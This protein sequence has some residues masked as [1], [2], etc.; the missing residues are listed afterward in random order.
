MS[1]KIKVE[2]RKVKDLFTYEFNNKNHTEKQINFLV[3]SITEFWFNT[4]II[5][6]KNN[7]IIAG[8]WRL[9]AAKKLWLEEV[10]VVE[11]N[12]LTPAQVKKYRLLDN[13]IA[14]LAEDNEENIKMELLELQDPQLNELYDFALN[15]DADG[16]WDDFDLPDED[17][18]DLCQM[19]FTLHRDQKEEIEKAMESAALLGDYGDTWNENKNGNALARVAE[20]FN[21]QTWE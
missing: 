7:I 15:L 2:Y 19:T 9:E 1:E 4:P 16:L 12:D 13:K 21:S 10:P 14:E 8:H 5:V 11:K 6:D 3:N 17:K 20:L 18:G